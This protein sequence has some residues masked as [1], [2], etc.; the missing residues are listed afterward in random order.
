MGDKHTLTLAELEKLANSGKKTSNPRPDTVGV[1]RDPRS[2]KVLY[3]DENGK[4]TTKD[5]GHTR[6]LPSALGLNSNVHGGT[7]VNTEFPGYY[8]RPVAGVANLLGLTGSQGQPLYPNR[9]S[10]L[11][12]SMAVGAR[13][14]DIRKH[15]TVGQDLTPDSA[16][17]FFVNM[18]PMKR[19][20]IEYQLYIGG[21]YKAKHKFIPGAPANDADR[22]A[23]KQLLMQ[24]IKQNSGLARGETQGVDSILQQ[25]ADSARSSGITPDQ[26]TNAKTKTQSIASQTNTV[27]N[28][29][30]LNQS[31][32]A[33]FADALGRNPTK[34]ETDRFVQ[35]YQ[36][37]EIAYQ[38]SIG[39]VNPD[40]TL[41]NPASS[42]SLGGIPAYT[43]TPSGTPTVVGGGIQVGLSPQTIALNPAAQPGGVGSPG[44]T[45]IAPTTVVQPASPAAAAAEAARAADPTGAAAYSVGNRAQDFYNALI[46]SPAG[47][48]TTSKPTN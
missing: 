36:G 43:A 44:S 31:L 19:A 11:P 33:A 16:M 14:R 1:V 20:Q 12:G 4:Q 32:R 27:T 26:A 9:D 21:Y 5:K 39:G 29:A 18:D 45:P 28:P 48:I 23:F 42:I 46:G 30:D 47:N 34:A 10:A 24:G 8:D 2:G 37:K 25:T 7:S 22:A 35:S 15:P 13:S 40:G 38:N 3:F 41:I 17:Q 6:P